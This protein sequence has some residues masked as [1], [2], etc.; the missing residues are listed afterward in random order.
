MVQ[1]IL[2][3]ENIQVVLMKSHLAHKVTARLRK[4]YYSLSLQK[5]N[6]TGKHSNPYML[7]QFSCPIYLVSGKNNL[8]FRRAFIKSACNIGY[9]ICLNN[10]F[11]P[12][13]SSKTLC[14]QFAA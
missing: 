9:P 14:V 2:Y 7:G 11:N 6:C 4:N 12:G 8:L 10:S 13:K 5:K 3:P 1:I